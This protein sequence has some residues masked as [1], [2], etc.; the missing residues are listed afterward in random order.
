MPFLRL[1]AA[2]VGVFVSVL[3]TTA[4]SPGQMALLRGALVGE[5]DANRQNSGYLLDEISRRYED[6][7]GAD[8]KAMVNMPE[9][10]AALTA[11]AN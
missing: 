1:C 6:S 9:R 11:E 4:L 8:A 5:F 10:I 7:D 3:A 2:V